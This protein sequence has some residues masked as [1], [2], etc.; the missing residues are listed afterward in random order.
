M[1]R[2]LG[3]LALFGLA[4]P[5]YA[6][7]VETL[8][9]DHEGDIY[10]VIMI[11]N[12]AASVA[13]VRAVLTDY[14][15]LSALNAAIVESDVLPAPNENATRVRTRTKDCI[16]FL[17]A[18]ITRVDDVTRDADGGFRATIVPRLSDMKSGLARWR[19]QSRQDTTRIAFEA[20]M[21]P[22]FWIP[23]LIGPAL[24]KYRLRAHLQETAVNLE[25]LAAS[26]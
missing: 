21:E 16:L 7:E 6:G 20:R 8:D 10:H 13:R 15:H 18:D 22:D 24:I 12:V 17:C 4:P 14:T 19:L 11:F 26:H 3:V 25:R 9:V 5:L 2:L 23:P 1:I